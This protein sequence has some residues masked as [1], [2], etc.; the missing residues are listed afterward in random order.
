MN[1]KTYAKFIN[2]T[3]VQTARLIT[4]RTGKIAF[5]TSLF[6]TKPYEININI[7]FFDNE[8][9]AYNWIEKQDK[10]MVNN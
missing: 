10:W 5:E 1:N 7:P 6:G 4:L 8:E 9:D 3:M 2:G